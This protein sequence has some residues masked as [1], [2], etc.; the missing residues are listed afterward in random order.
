MRCLSPHSGYSIQVFEAEEQIVV[1]PRGAA[2]S[3]VLKKPVIANF[4]Q[5]GLLDHEIEWALTYFNFTGLPDGV[6]PLTRVASFDVTAYV[7]QFKEDKQDAMYVQICDR[8]RQLQKLNPSEFIIVEQ[9]RA[10]I[11]WPS[12]DEDSVE[13]ILTF[14]ER[15]KMD[16]QGIRVYEHENQAR[17]EIVDAMDKLERIAAGEEV[18]PEEVQVSA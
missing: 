5:G 17:P 11:P 16:P 3:H 1:D 7:Q 14:Q 15:L 8:L 2:T 10:P 13:D 6:N 12:Y 18:E 9:P 4:Q